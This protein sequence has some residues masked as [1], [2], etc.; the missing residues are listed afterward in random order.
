MKEFDWPPIKCPKA[1]VLM[2]NFSA[3][4]YFLPPFLNTLPNLKSLILIN[5][6]SSS[7][8]LGN[9]SAFTAVHNLRSLWL[10]KIT[11]PPLPRTTIPL[12][13]LR[14]ISLVLCDLKAGL[15]DPLVDLRAT[16]PLLSHVAIDHSMDLAELP[17]SI[18][19]LS[20]L[21]NLSVSN[22]HGLREL[23][24]DVGKLESLRIL[25]VYACP[26]LKKLPQSI[27][28]LKKL[29]YLD[30][31]QCVSLRGLPAELGDLSGLE[32]I[33]M[34]ECL[35]LRDIPRS[36]R[37]R[38]SSLH[39]VCDED[40]ALLWKEGEKDVAPLRVQVVEERF[41]LDWLVE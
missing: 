30:I 10:E 35:Q 9:I 16:F 7:A 20:S 6:A 19:E 24:A 13:N 4:T 18:C 39:V 14:K 31:S 5:G 1:E 25:R 38:D 29:K 21:E 15:Q 11:L 34:R 32:K 12:R 17:S 27:C 40:V 26:A 41:D 28:R 36:F 2:I 3:E 8:A 23:P 37:A 22:C 33:D